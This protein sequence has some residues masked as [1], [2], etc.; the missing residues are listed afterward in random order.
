LRSPFLHLLAFNTIFSPE[1]AYGFIHA[2]YLSAFKVG[3]KSM[4]RDETVT[5]KTAK[6]LFDPKLPLA[7]FTE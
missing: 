2:G 5:P 6:H 3:A 4:L 1:G 7:S